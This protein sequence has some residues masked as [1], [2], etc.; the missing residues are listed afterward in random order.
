MAD[1]D[2]LILTCVSL[3]FGAP[4]RGDI[5]VLGILWRNKSRATCPAD[6]ASLVDET[7]YKIVRVLYLAA[8]KVTGE[9]T[10][11]GRL[12]PRLVSTESESSFLVQPRVRSGGAPAAPKANIVRGYA[13]AGCFTACAADRLG[14]VA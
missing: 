12:Q 3:F 9:R 1:V 11:L 2:Y 6:L 7:H 10:R 14:A 5:L 4:S 13:C 8:H